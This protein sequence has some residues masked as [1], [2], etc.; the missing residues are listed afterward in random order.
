MPLTPSLGNKGDVLNMAEKL[1]E[2][3]RL[4]VSFTTY[5]GKVQAVRDVSFHIERG[6]CIGIVG[7]SG[8]GKSVTAHSILGLIP[9]PS[10]SVESGE[11]FLEGRD[12]L[13]LSRPQLQKVRGKD[14]ESRERY[15]A[16]PGRDKYSFAFLRRKTS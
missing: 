13:K 15:I 6:E 11:I 2:V 3:K 8:C 4:S 10:G 16:G 14:R 7:E 1:L 5:L 12:L 9:S